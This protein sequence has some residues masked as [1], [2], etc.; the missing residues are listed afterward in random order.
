MSNYEKEYLKYK[1]RYLDLKKNKLNNFQDELKKLYPKV[2]FDKDINIDYGNNKITYGELNYDG[3]DKILR[4][5]KNDFNSF[6]DIGSG[7]GKLCLHIS[8]YPD[9]NKSI[10]IELVKERHL[11]ALSLKNKLKNYQNVKKVQFI[12]DDIFKINLGNLFNKDDLIL[13]WI[14]NL[15]FDIDFNSK[16]FSKLIKELPKDTIIACSKKPENLDGLLLVDQIKVPMSWS[17]DSEV[18][19]LKIN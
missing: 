17:E 3:L 10:G 1:K 12:N 2:Q 9:I 15:C 6:L 8:N 14:S 4:Y 7:R 11:D 19:L 16:L 5:F 13:I 18:Y